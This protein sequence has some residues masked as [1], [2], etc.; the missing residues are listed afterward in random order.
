MRAGQ[1][2]KNLFVPDAVEQIALISRGIPRLINIICD[3]ALLAAFQGW[4]KSISPEM[5]QKIA[6]DLR[7]TEESEP[8]SDGHLATFCRKPKTAFIFQ[9]PQAKTLRV[10]K[11]ITAF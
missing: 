7:L 8:R 11:V 1:E 6:H 3:T 2:Y 5:I 10:C 4:S 9:S